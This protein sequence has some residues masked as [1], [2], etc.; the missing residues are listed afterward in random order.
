MRFSFAFE[1]DYDYDWMK[2]L[3]EIYGISN[4][5]EYRADIFEKHFEEQADMCEII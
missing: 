2:P 1:A 4:L 5:V 3:G